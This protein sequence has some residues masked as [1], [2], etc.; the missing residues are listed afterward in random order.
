MRTHEPVSV[1]FV[2]RLFRLFY[3]HAVTPAVGLVVVVVVVVATAAAATVVMVEVVVA[4]IE[5]VE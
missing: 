5:A 4:A 1:H 3:T 2:V